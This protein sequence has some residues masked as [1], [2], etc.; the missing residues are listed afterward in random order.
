MTLILNGILQGLF[1]W[2]YGLFLD[3]I[4]YCANAL[5][6]VMSTDLTFFEANVPVIGSMITVFIAMGWALL[7]GNF[8]FQ[9]MKSMLSG[10]GFEA[11]SPTTLF[12]R[13]FIFGFM[14][15]GSRAICNIGLSIAKNMIDLLGVPTEVTLTTPGA[16]SFSAGDASWVLVI[17]IGVVLGIQLIKLFFEIG[18]RYV[19]VALLTFMAPLGFAMGGSKSTKEIFSG[20]IRMYASMLLMMIMN[21]VF[22]KLLLSAL[23][24]MPTGLL[25]LP[26]CILVVAIAKTARKIDNIISKIGLN[27][28]ITGD[29]LGRG[30][31]MMA[32]MAAR[33]VMN[34]VSK[35]KGAT[36]KGPSKGGSS[37]SSS[38]TSNTG[39]R[40]ATASTFNGNS[41]STGPTSN[42][43]N[44][45]NTNANTQANQ[46]TSANQKN[47]SG[48]NANT[49][50]N[51]TSRFGSNSNAQN[52]NSNVSGGGVSSQSS[53]KS[54]SSGNVA[55]AAGK[56]GGTG[57]HSASGGSKVNTNRFGSGNKS[58]TGVNKSKAG[59]NPASAV[60]SGAA[61]SASAVANKGKTVGT[62]STAKT[63]KSAKPGTNAPKKSTSPA[64]NKTRGI[65]QNA[66]AK[67]PSNGGTKS[68][69]QKNTSNVIRPPKNTGG[70]NA[71]APAPKTSETAE[72]KADKKPQM[73]ISI[74][75][76]EDV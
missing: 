27:P 30:A 2:L 26:W 7:L 76:D 45:G 34:S 60:K 64:A 67:K 3:L 36:P 52:T 15:L 39:A 24:T 8:V 5:L 62:P 6:G 12:A 66:Q 53:H 37:R 13:T 57:S 20:Y 46:N 22:L 65:K 9:A 69:V 47:Q 40:S 43:G 29:P 23:S 44:Y 1:E 61:K 11:E 16:D 41:Q 28:A 48:T 17:I 31:G 70:K 35:T 58:S 50:A 75:V 55:T 63:K 73:N 54:M 33:T 51:Q 10:L 19:V 14:L 32:Y 68:A 71:S 21:V 59:V 18:E 42:N 56:S 72:K 49:Q 4:A 25:V 74:E 38:S